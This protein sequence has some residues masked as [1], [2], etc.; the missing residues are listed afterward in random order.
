MD[1]HDADLVER[2]VG[3][4]RGGT[5]VLVL[6]VSGPDP[7]PQKAESCSKNGAGRHVEPGTL[8]EDCQTRYKH[9]QYGQQ[10]TKHAV[11]QWLRVLG[12]REEAAN[13]PKEVRIRSREYSKLNG[14]E[15][16]RSNQL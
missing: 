15:G 10:K 4:V 2:N 9:G 8:E 1:I 3:G 5:G 11:R 12:M 13:P 16:R 7:P 6:Q 14:S